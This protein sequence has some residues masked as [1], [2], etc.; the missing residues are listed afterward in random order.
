MRRLLLLAACGM[1]AAA[2]GCK[3][4]DFPKENPR[5]P[6]DLQKQAAAGAGPSEMGD[7]P[8]EPEADKPADGEGGE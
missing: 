2:L 6:A 8:A 4:G 3:G 1:L 5:L 7:I